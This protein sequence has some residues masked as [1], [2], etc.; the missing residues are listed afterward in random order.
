MHIK[1]HFTDF[2]QNFDYQE[3]FFWKF[4][5]DKY[6]LEI[7]DKPDVLIYGPFGQD[8]RKFNCIRIFHT[9][10]N[11]RPNFLECDF[12]F[13]FDLISDQRNYRFPLYAWYNQHKKLLENR[14]DNFDI[15]NKSFCNFVYSNDKALERIDFFNKLSNYKKVDSGGRFMNNIGYQV[16]NKGQ[17]ISNYKFTICFENESYP[18]YTS[19]KIYDAMLANSVPIYWGNPL[20]HEEF[21]PKSFINVHDFSSLDAVVDKVIELDSNDDLYFQMLKEPFFYNNEIPIGLRE[22]N[23]HKQ[24]EY[25]FS[26]IGSYIPVSNRFFSKMH[27]YR[28]DFKSWV[29]LKIN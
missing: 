12:A 16:Q 25:I 18:R 14:L 17:F 22:E 11:I 7:S 15:K 8:H 19:E 24:F 21:N 4:L 10:E 28:K 27:Y 9:G 23:I 26:L 29:K 2:W 6:D 1:I 3:S 20:I 5:S 13:S